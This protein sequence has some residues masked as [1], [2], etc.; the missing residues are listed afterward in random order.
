MD[1]IPS[2]LPRVLNQLLYQLPGCQTRFLPSLHGS[3]A[4]AVLAYLQIQVV[5]VVLAVSECN[6]TKLHDGME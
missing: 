5:Q 2:I 6:Q 3:H 4:L 1:L